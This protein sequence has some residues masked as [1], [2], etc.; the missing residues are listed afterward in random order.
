MIA[1]DTVEA[2]ECKAVSDALGVVPTEVLRHYLTCK[3]GNAAV[4]VAIHT[5]GLMP[6]CSQCFD[7]LNSATGASE[8]LTTT[9][10]FDKLDNNEKARMLTSVSARRVLSL[11]IFCNAWKCIQRLPRG[12]RPIS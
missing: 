11:W 12:T 1:A 3:C 8:L 9:V 2:Y 10:A 6:F 5:C 4:I 7:P